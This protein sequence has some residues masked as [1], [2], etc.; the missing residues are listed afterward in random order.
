MALK[1]VA[2]TP[3][4]PD[5]PE[6]ATYW[7]EL[8]AGTEVHLSSLQRMF[9]KLPS[10]PRCK[11]CN[12]PFS[13][14]FA[15]VLKL[16]GFRRWALNQQMCRVCVRSLE[17]HDGGAEV[18]VSLVYVDVRGSTATAES[19]AARDFS[20]GLARY[21]GVVSGNVDKENGIIDHMAGDGVMALWI[22]AFVGPEH[23]LSALRAAIHIAR[24]VSG[25]VDRGEG[26]PAGVGVHTGTAYVGVVGEPGSRDFTALGDPANTVARLSSAAD[27]GEVV[28][29]QSIVDGTGI[30]TDGLEHRLLTLKGKSEPFEAWAWKVGSEDPIGLPVTA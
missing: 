9:G 11:L 30:A 4:Q 18:A 8:L 6:R 1:H 16:F 2:A 24:D 28:I 3:Y 22:P 5:D 20:R 14:P 12:A 17:K 19:M 27:A 29:S 23:P 25:A 21:L 7:G 26:W 15:P 13:G 10:P